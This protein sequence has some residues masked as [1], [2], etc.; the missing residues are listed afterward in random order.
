MKSNLYE[1]SMGAILGG[2]SN[3]AA[4]AR[5]SGGTVRQRCE[6]DTIDNERNCGATINKSPTESLQYSA[7]LFPPGI[8]E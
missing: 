4:V 8:T 7:L 6:Q 1:H 2:F 3:T 5:D